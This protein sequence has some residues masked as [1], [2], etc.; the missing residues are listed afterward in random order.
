MKE[1]SQHASIGMAMA[2]LHK[3]TNENTPP[4]TILKNLNARFEEQ[5]DSLFPAIR[6]GGGK[7]DTCGPGIKAHE[8]MEYG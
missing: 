7:E 2:A 6:H 3:V 5:L 4:A 8:L 1:K